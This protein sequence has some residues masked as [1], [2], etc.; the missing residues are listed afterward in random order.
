MFPSY[1]FR[2]FAFLDDKFQMG[3]LGND[4]HLKFVRVVAPPRAALPRISDT[5]SCF[6]RLFYFSF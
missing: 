3:E 6:C 4:D 2:R 1:P 5:L